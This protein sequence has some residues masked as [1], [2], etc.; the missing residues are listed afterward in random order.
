MR[1]LSAG[2]GKGLADASG[3]KISTYGRLLFSFREFPGDG[4]ELIRNVLQSFYSY[5]IAASLGGSAMCCGVFQRTGLN[6]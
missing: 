4:S 2:V 5:S 6:K 3:I 1:L